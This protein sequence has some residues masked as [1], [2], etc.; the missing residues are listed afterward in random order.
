MKE[1]SEKESHPSY[2][3]AGFSRVTGS[4]PL[5]QSHVQCQSMVMLRIAPAEVEHHLG[6]DWVHR[7][8][9]QYIEVAFSPAQFAQLLTTMNVGDGVP[10]T[11]IRYEGKGVE[12]PPSQVP[13]ATKVRET[14]KKDIEQLIANLGKICDEQEEILSKPRINK[15]DKE[16][17]RDITYRTYRWISDSAPFLA[18]C[19]G[20][21][22][23]KVVTQAKA[24]IDNFLTTVAIQTGLAELKKKMSVPVLEHSEPEQRILD[25]NTP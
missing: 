8:G 17:L 13:E 6:R 3:L 4:M 18:E 11:I 22:I 5:F 10:C 2:A 1:R 19:F 7:S 24:E 14:F 25:D 12:E 16:A 20:E 23:G 21:N 15:A 9:K